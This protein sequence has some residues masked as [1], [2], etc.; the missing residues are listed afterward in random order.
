MLMSSEPGAPA[1]TGTIPL[2]VP[3]LRGREAEYLAECVSSGWVSSVG[4]FVDRFEREV[5]GYVGAQRGV[6]TVNGTSALHL[7]L[8]VAGV[9]PDDEVLVSDIT[10]IA[11]ANAV[12]Y[13]GAWPVF[14][15]AE[16]EHWQIDPE[17]VR[18]F[19]EEECVWR[20]GALFNKATQR[21]VRAL[22]AVHVLGH[23]V[24][25]DPLIEITKKYGLAL[26]EDCAEAIG[27]EYRGQRVGTFGDAAA[28]S[29][30]GN[31]VITC[32]GGGM[33]ISKN[34]AWLERA[35]YLS[36]QAKDDPLEYVHHAVGYNYRL[37][38]LQ[39]A[40]GCAQLELLDSF[41]EIKRA[42]AARY[43]AAFAEVPALSFMREAAWAKS[44]YWLSTVL[45]DE[46]Q[47]GL[48]SRA[49]LRQL[50]ARGIQSRPLWQPLHL[51]PAFAG[52]QSYR[53]AAGRDLHRD[54]LSLP[55]STGLT[56]DDQQR[57]VSEILAAVQP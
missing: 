22:I 25:L 46:A 24:H 23:P 18:A 9:Q 34:E 39:A 44:I 52:C 36:T 2:S 6:A 57:V 54:A 13:A 50:A 51:S 49:L 48:S 16:P 47:C 56:A 37:T 40:V 35:K 11:P 10:F 32:G 28:F 55:S 8:L 3:E 29:F 42:I 20:D 21:R 7:A 5:A 27:T 12:R 4:P 53:C 1:T 45:V 41:L 30:N 43:A 15:G 17:A 38:N 31:K 14:I 26:I 33:L 19:C